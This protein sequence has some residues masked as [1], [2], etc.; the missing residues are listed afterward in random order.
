MFYQL[1]FVKK[2]RANV[3]EALELLKRFGG[4]KKAAKSFGVYAISF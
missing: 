3:L 1:V 2:K 4:N